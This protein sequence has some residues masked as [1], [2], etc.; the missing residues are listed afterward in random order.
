M[1][2]TRTAARAPMLG[3]AAAF[4]VIAG[5]VAPPAVVAQRGSSRR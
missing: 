1:I 2:A 5:L 3:A 4:V